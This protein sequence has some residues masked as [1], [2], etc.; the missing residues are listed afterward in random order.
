MAVVNL[1]DATLDQLMQLSTWADP[2]PWRSVVEGRDQTTGDSSI[3]IGPHNGTGGRK[4]SRV[5][6]PGGPQSTESRE[7]R[8]YGRYGL[9]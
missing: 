5:G 4:L 2:P 1:D 7:L 9:Y 3:M 6:S 8:F